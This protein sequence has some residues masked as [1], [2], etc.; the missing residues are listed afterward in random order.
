MSKR[1]TTPRS[2][3]GN[4]SDIS[5]ESS[6]V[7]SS[8][9]VT[10]S[11]RHQNASAFVET[12]PQPVLVKDS[13]HQPRTTGLFGL[14]IVGLGGANGTV[15]LAGILANRLNLSWRGPHGEEMTPNYYGCITQLDQKGGGV[16]YRDRVRGLANA[17]MAAIGGWVSGV[18]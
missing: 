7:Y 8:V 12:S 5:G 3:A 18:L 1:V 4:N 6:S 15:C 9:S 14:M 17:S 13:Q 2:A 11:Y 16:G 10:S